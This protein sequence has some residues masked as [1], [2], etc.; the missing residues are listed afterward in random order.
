[1]VKLNTNWR[2]SDQGKAAFLTRPFGD[3][4]KLEPVDSGLLKRDTLHYIQEKGPPADFAASLSDT[5]LLELKVVQMYVF[6]ISQN[7]S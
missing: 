5:E 7:E 4:R 1:M 3:Y 6:P 2:R